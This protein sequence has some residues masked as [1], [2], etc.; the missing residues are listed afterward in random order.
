MRNEALPSPLKGGDG[1][2]IYRGT[3]IKIIEWKIEHKNVRLFRI[4]IKFIYLCNKLSLVNF[5]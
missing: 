4:I 5:D 3:V 1:S 2:L